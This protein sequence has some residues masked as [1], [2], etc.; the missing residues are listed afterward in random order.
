M[1]CTFFGHRDTPYNIKEKLKVVL[2]DLIENKNVKMFYIG[3]NG[4]FD[5]MSRDILRELKEKYNINYYVVLAY[6]P[7][8]KE[9]EDY[10]DTIYFDELNTKPYKCRIIERNK[11]MLEKS[12]IVVTHV[13]RIIG[14]AVEF[15][16]MAEKKGKIV[17]NIL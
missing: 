8:K 6:I 13:T 5:K 16:N 14:G 2:I 17:I 3:D 1:I 11:I 10:S 9:N 12:D 15:K 7:S 4:A